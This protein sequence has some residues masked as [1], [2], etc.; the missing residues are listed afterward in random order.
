MIFRYISTLNKYEYTKEY[1]IK[2]AY[3]NIESYL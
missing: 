1:Q 2:G 3:H